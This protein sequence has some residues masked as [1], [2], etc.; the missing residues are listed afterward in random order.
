MQL[1]HKSRTRV[2]LLARALP[3]GRCLSVYAGLD[4]YAGSRV[5]RR[6][7]SEVADARTAKEAE[8][9]PRRTRRLAASRR[10]R[11]RTSVPALSSHT[12]HTSHMSDP[13]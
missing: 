11:R 6:Q 13:G 1:C 4:S 9:V 2:P 10:G 8:S 7:T 12:S 3:G 5:A